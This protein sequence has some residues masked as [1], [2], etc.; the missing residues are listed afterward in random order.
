[1]TNIRY[2][3]HQDV[4]LLLLW[5]KGWAEELER[6]LQAEVVAVTA[7]QAAVLAVKPKAGGGQNEKE[8]CS[9]HPNLISSPFPLA[10]PCYVNLPVISFC[11]P[12]PRHS[13][14]LLCRSPFFCYPDPL[15]SSLIFLSPSSCI[16]LSFSRNCS[17]PQ[18]IIHHSFYTFKLVW[19][20]MLEC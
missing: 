9:N 10:S 5:Q 4:Q 19:L 1:M 8:A 14:H 13:I 16:S 20:K 3:H 18:L 12:D 15:V 7:S 17:F 2:D 11:Y 6:S